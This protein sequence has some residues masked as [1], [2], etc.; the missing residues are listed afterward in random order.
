[1][2]E[3][4][5]NYKTP[6][7]FDDIILTSDGINL[8][9][10]Y[11]EKSNDETKHQ[12]EYEIKKLPVFEETIKWL[13][14]YFSG[15]IPDF[16]PTIKINN[17]TPFREKVIKIMSNIPYGKVVT[18]ND[19]AKEIAKEENIP[20]MSAQ[21]VGGAVGW[22]PICIIIPCHRVVGT[23]KSLTGY[24]GGIKNKIALLKLEK[25]DINNF[26]IPKKGTKLWKDAFGVI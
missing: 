12:K 8:T 18:Y 15:N 22:N 26:I 2:K 24:G 21:A 5:Y 4:K 16:T 19:I 17:L 9:G 11:F 25:Q 7:N 3:F 20:K 1:M 23:N 6:N 14:I 10:L 13:D